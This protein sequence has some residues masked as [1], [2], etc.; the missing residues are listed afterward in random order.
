MM[1]INLCLKGKTSGFERPRAPVLQI[2]WGIVNQANIDY[3]ERISVL[4]EPN[5][6]SLGW[7]F[8]MISSLMTFEVN[9]A[10]LEK[11]AKHQ[12]YLAGEEVSDPDSPAH[13][14]AKRATKQTKALS[15]IKSSEAPP[16]AKRSKAGK[17]TKKQKPK[18]PL[19]LVDEFVDE[20]VPLNEPKIGDEEADIQKAIEA[21]LKEIHDAPRGPLP[22]VVIREP[23]FGKFQP[24]PEVLG[25]G[26]EKV[27][28]E[29]AAQFLLNLKT[30][31]KKSLA[32][33][34]IFQKRTPAPTDPSGHEET[35]SL[36]AELGLSNSDTESD[37]EV[38][39][40]V[41]SGAQDVGQAGPNPGIQDEGKARPNPGDNAEYQPQSTLVVHAGPNLEHTDIEAT[42]ASNRP[43]PEQMDEGFISTAYPNVQEN[44]KLTVE[45]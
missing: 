38:P 29:Q 21:S 34:Y 2:L 24:L 43:H 28:E 18:S 41:K 8:R 23:E 36:Y 15:T 17:V 26:K 22:P 13:K 11:V 12:R 42:D 1:I 45:E 25:N 27:G 6:K 5:G 44:L 40:V 3:A 20:G 9:N 32:E 37:K 33:Q 7:L 16:L 30:P 19:Q 35:S 4:R 31:K 14:P 10:Y 39:P